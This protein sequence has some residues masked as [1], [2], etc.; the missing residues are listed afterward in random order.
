MKPPQIILHIPQKLLKTHQKESL[1]SGEG[2]NLQIHSLKIHVLCC[3][4]L[5]SYRDSTCWVKNTLKR[6]GL[7]ARTNMVP[8]K[9]VSLVNN[10]VLFLFWTCLYLMS[11]KNCCFLYFSF[12]PNF[13]KSNLNF[14]QQPNFQNGS[15]RDQA[16][17]LE[18][19]R[20][21]RA[22]KKPN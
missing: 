17:K 13:E 15:V 8:A 18:N 5:F 4:F 2:A 10:I 6:S 9:N 1:C 3:M 20:H 11:P 7:N 21:Q 14:F 12:S 16:R 22:K 19:P